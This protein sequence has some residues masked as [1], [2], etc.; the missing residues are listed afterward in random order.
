MKQ[1][2]AAPTK[3]GGLVAI[4]KRKCS[5]KVQP[6]VKIG[7]VY[8]VLDVGTTQSG[9]ER[10]VCVE[11]EM[12]CVNHQPKRA[13]INADRFAWAAVTEKDVAYAR[14][15]ADDA[16]KK[17][18]NYRFAQAK[19]KATEKLFDSEVVRTTQELIRTMTWDEHVE[20]TIKPL[21]VTE[22]AWMMAEACCKYCAENKISEVLKVTRGIRHL[23]EEYYN[24]LA[25]DLDRRNINDL[26]EK[27]T[28]FLSSP[29]LSLTMER[30]KLTLRNEYYASYGEVPY[31]DLRCMATLGI[32][33]IAAY[34][35]RVER[36]NA[37]IGQKAK[38]LIDQSIENALITDRLFAQ[39]DALLGDWVIEQSTH[40]NTF[41]AILDN[42]INHMKVLPLDEENKIA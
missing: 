32:I 21:I 4:K 35:R 41:E 34:K 18:L 7:Q 17:I 13:T 25:I 9:A 19:K 2:T 14:K 1:P 15:K 22:L 40:I 23:K 11:H 10:L 8:K 16:Y 3:V 12:A 31:I 20:I 38:G 26:R 24:F 29:V 33:F 36:A 28:A 39:F 27:A 30:M 37:L 5:P 42:H 6:G